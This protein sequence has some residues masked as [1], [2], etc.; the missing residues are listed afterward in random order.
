MFRKTLVPMFWRTIMPTID[1]IAKR[2]N[3]NADALGFDKI[4]TL[5]QQYDDSTISWSEFK[6][7]TRMSPTQART[8]VWGR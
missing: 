2:W 5:I 7:L 8:W 3:D 4:K 6:A 1:E